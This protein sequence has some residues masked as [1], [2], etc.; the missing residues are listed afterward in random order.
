MKIRIGIDYRRRRRESCRRRISALPG[1]SPKT[2]GAGRH[3]DNLGL[4][5]EDDWQIGPLLSM[6][7]CRRPHSILRRAST[8][9]VTPAG[10]LVERRV[11]A[12]GPSDGP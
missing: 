9:A 10:A 11:I 12:P 2:G 7:A 5:V 4:F 3:H 6:A 8:V 1:A